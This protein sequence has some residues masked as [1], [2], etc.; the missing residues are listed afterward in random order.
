MADAAVDRNAQQLS[1]SSSINR[2]ILQILSF[3][4]AFGIRVGIPLLAPES[5][6]NVLHNRVELFTPVT[7]FRNGRDEQ[8]T[9]PLLLRLIPVSSKE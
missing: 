9:L 1:K 5:W 4:F 6:T 3:A 8:H 2:P 7:G